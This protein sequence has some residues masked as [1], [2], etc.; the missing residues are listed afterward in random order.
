MKPLL[1]IPSGECSADEVKEMKEAGY[2]VI[3]TDNPEKFKFIQKPV[4]NQVLL[5]HLS[6]VVFETKGQTD[7]ATARE[8]LCRLILHSH[9][10]P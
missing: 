3:V 6:K 8:W 7:M 5:N 9:I 10:N 4:D 1:I 2:I